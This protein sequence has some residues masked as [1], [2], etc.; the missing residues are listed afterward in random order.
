M[1]FSKEKD[2]NFDFFKFFLHKFDTNRGNNFE[3]SSFCLQKRQITLVIERCKDW[4]E[5]KP[6]SKQETHKVAIKSDNISKLSGKVVFF[7]IFLSLLKRDSDK[8]SSKL[9]KN[10]KTTANMPKTPNL[11]LFPVAREN[12]LK[13]LSRSRLS[14]IAF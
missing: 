2:K 8:M 1:G 10:I 14:F 12:V 3:K 9:F 4:N 6:S 7:C 5:I 13:W 11:Y